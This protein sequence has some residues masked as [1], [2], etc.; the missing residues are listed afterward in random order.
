LVRNV[1]DGVYGWHLA[2]ERKA[3]LEEEARREGSPLSSLVERVTDDWLAE[4]NSVS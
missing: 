1:E 2:A 3:E 4:H